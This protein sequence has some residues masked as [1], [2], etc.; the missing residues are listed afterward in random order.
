MTRGTRHLVAVVSTLRGI[1]RPR[2]PDNLIAVE[3]DSLRE[4]RLLVVAWMTGRNRVEHLRDIPL[5]GLV[6]VFLDHRGLDDLVADSTESRL[7]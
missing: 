7:T 6:G 5:P 4:M 3:A 2:A 1:L